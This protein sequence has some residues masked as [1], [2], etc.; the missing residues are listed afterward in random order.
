MNKESKNISLFKY[1]QEQQRKRKRKW[2]SD[3]VLNKKIQKSN[4]KLSKLINNERNGR[5]THYNRSF[6]I[7]AHDSNDKKIYPGLHSF[8]K[9]RYFPD[10]NEQFPDKNRKCIK[11]FPSKIKRSCELYGKDHGLLVHSQIELFIENN[12]ILLNAP[13]YIDKCTE[14]ILNVFE[15]MNWL[16]ICSEFMIF[17]EDL[18]VATSID[19][20]VFDTKNQKLILIELKTGYECENYGPLPN[21]EYFHGKVMKCVKNCPYNRHAIQVLYMKLILEKKYDTVIDDC[22]IILTRSK[23]RDTQLIPLPDWTK[24]KKFVESIYNQ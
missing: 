12:F 7:I 13:N 24:D 2:N 22:F 9:M 14:R 23:H 16:P 11:Y 21:D 20:L 1:R 3:F 6:K 18:K 8:I 17:D 19:V 5:I 15:E 10:T 4:G